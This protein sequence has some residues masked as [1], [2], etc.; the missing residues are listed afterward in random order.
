MA[1][2]TVKP[3]AALTAA[4][5]MSCKVLTIP[6]D[7]PMRE[8]A[9]TLLRAQVSG[10]PVVD[11]QGRCVGILSA[12]DF[13]QRAGRLEAAISAQR[14]PGDPVRRHMTTDLVTADPETHI[15]TLARTMID[16]RIHRLVIVDEERRPIGI[17]SSTDLLA[18][19]AY[20]ERAGERTFTHGRMRQPVQPELSP[21][22]RDLYAEYG[23]G[24]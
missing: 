8:A 20:G 17:V 24:D 2:T 11:A 6:Q 23:V 10:A 9:Q 15:G 18:A 5:L 16:G 21:L 3:F 19:I 1:T 14:A 12:A 7:T 13:V 4:D 22:E